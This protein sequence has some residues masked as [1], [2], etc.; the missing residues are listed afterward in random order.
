MGFFHIWLW[1]CMMFLTFVHDV[2]YIANLFPLIAE[3]YIIVN[4]TTFQCGIFDQ[5]RGVF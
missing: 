5:L 1:L 2:A 3:H 4:Y